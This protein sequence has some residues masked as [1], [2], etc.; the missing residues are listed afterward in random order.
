MIHP[1][2][3][4]FVSSSHLIEVVLLYLVVKLLGKFLVPSVDI[5]SLRLMDASFTTLSESFLATIDAT[6]ERLLSS[7]C[8]VVLYQILLESKSLIACFTL[9]VLLDLMFFHMALQ[10]VFSLESTF[11]AKYVT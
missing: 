4:S 3:I 7:M 8:E 9:E 1:L 11:A 6:N 10:T 2:S 5:M